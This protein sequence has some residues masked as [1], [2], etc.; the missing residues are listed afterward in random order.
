MVNFN[1]D[2]IRRG[3]L[4]CEGPDGMAVRQFVPED[5]QAIFD[6]IDYDRAHL[7]QEHSG[8]RDRTADHYKT[9]EDVRQSIEHSQDPSRLR[10]GIWFNGVMV[11]SNN[12]TPRGGGQVES[13]SWVGKQYIGH[14]FANRGRELL[15]G[16]AFDLGY[17]QVVSKYLLA[18]TLAAGR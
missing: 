11:G 13:G 14:D 6:L 5:D 8:I 1:Q 18:I 4:E 10:F 17:D 16:I 15:L 12:L 9:V 2:P 7:S 3:R